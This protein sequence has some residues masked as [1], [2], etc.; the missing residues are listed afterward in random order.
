[1]LTPKPGNDPFGSIRS[2][3]G[4]R[5]T[6]PNLNIKIHMNVVKIVYESNYRYNLNVN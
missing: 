5:P 1:M 3:V 2:S 6:L 4:L